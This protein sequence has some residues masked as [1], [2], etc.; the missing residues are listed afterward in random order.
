MTFQRAYNRK[1]YYCIGI[2][3]A[4]MTRICAYLPQSYLRDVKKNTKNVQTSSLLIEHM[5]EWKHS[6]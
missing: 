1:L 5:R 4:R 2:V 6:L 3:P